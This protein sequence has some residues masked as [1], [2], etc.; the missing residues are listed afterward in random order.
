MTRYVVYKYTCKKCEKSDLRDSLASWSVPG[1]V[2]PEEV[3]SYQ[4]KPNCVF[5]GHGDLRV[6]KATTEE[7]RERAMQQRNLGRLFLDD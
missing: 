2:T 6:E 7:R 5:C 4:S 3:K 1:T